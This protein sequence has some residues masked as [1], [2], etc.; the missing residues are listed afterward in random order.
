VRGRAGVAFDRF[1][2]YVTGGVAFG[3]FRMT[4]FD[5][6]DFDS[7]GR[8]T[9]TGWTAG[10]GAEYALTN[11]WTVRGEYR[12]TDFGSKSFSTTYDGGSY[13]WI[14]RPRTHDFRIGASYKF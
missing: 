8:A 7:A 6:G 12:Y 2:P 3:G 14:A 9:L 10:V 11:N 1:L 5:D 4:E 13:D